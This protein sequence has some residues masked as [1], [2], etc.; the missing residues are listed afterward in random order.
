MGPEEWTTLLETRG[1]DARIIDLLRE[2][3]GTRAV[4][5][6]TTD[7]KQLLLA[8]EPD[9]YAAGKLA[10]T[11]LALFLEPDR[12]RRV[13]EQH[14]LATGVRNSDAVVRVPA[15]RLDDVATRS[16]VVQLVNE[17]LDRVAH[18]GSWNR[19]LA[20]TKKAQ[21]EMCS[22]HFVQKSL[23]GVCPDCD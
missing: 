21:G 1:V 5:P 12:A 18:E 10:K 19:G 15:A 8:V 16:L 22:V 9:G 20:D 4:E 2:V 3:S 6:P 17:A 14:N 13:S 7:T 11:T 23:T